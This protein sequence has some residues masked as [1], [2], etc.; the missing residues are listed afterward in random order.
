MATQVQTTPTLSTS[1]HQTAEAALSKPVETN[2]AQ[3]GEAV[4]QQAV[5]AHQ[6][7]S[8]SKEVI[9]T[10][11][12]HLSGERP[13]N[14]PPANPNASNAQNTTTTTQQNPTPQQPNIPTDTHTPVQAPNTAAPEQPTDTQTPILSTTPQPQQPAAPTSTLNP[15]RDQHLSEQDTTSTDA[16]KAAVPTDSSA[17]APVAGKSYKKVIFTVI[18]V[19]GA[20]ILIL[21]ILMITS[22][23]LPQAGALTPFFKALSAMT[24]KGAASMG[25]SP[26]GFSALVTSVGGLVLGF[27]IGGLVYTH[28]SRRK[29]EEFLNNTNGSTLPIAPTTLPYPAPVQQDRVEIN[30]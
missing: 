17:A 4:I 14:V 28:H 11:N 5:A 9:V 25:V 23:L 7:P 29:D 8:P 26:L 27:G 16:H 19:V 30:A 13:A 18:T 21:G 20:L 1:P 12:P 2:T 6:L 24:I 10:V 22:Q 15:Q 3:V